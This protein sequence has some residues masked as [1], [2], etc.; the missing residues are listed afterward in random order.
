M[1]GDLGFTKENTSKCKGIYCFD[2]NNED[3]R[4]LHSTGIKRNKRRKNIFSQN[5]ILPCPW[6]SRCKQRW[7][8]WRGSPT[9]QWRCRLEGLC[10]LRHHALRSTLWGHPPGSSH[11]WNIHILKLLLFYS[12]LT[13]KL[14]PLGSSFPSVCLLFHQVWGRDEP[15]RKDPVYGGY[16]QDT[17]ASAALGQ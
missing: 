10:C 3:M 14:G 2:S 6:S 12:I 17:M 1:G 5:S 7:W 16:I 8:T 9:A 13:L 15:L 4:K 11:S